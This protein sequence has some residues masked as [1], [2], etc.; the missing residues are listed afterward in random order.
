MV[1]TTLLASLLGLVVAGT[2]SASS[3]SLWPYPS[4]ASLS[5][6]G[7]CLSLSPSSFSFSASGYAS[8]SSVLSAALSRY[9]RLSFLP[10]SPSQPCLGGVRGSLT[11]LLVDVLTT[12]EVLGPDT[13][14]SYVLVVGWSN[15]TASEPISSLTARTVFGALRGLETFSQLVFDGAD[16][17]GEEFRIPQV[18]I[19]D[20]P[21]NNYRAI[22]IDTARIF[23]PVPLLK[24]FLDAMV[25]SKFNVLY[26][27]LT[28]NYQWT[29]EI[30][31]YPDLAT[32]CQPKGEGFYTQSDIA[33]LV[34]YAF[35]RGIRVIPEIDSPGHFDTINCYPE[36]MT[37]AYCPCAGA[38]DQCV[39]PTTFRATP[40]PS[41]SALWSFFEDLHGE[42]A[43]LF[44]D[45]Y[46]AI[47]GDE[48]WLQPWACSPAVQE[49]MVGEKLETLDAAAQW[50]EEAL[51][52]ITRKN[53][54]R[55]MMWWP[56]IESPSSQTIHVVWNGWPVIGGCWKCDFADFTGR[57]QDVLLSGPWYLDESGIDWKQW[58]QI[59]PLDFDGGDKKHML[60]GMGT[61]WSDL[62]KED[63]VTVA[64]PLMNSVAEQL[65]APQTVT[66]TPFENTETE[67]RY[68][69]QCSRLVQRGVLEQAQCEAL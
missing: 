49:W 26:L 48:A 50:Y 27:H 42:M 19:A 66:G 45:A 64:W 21:R 54:K 1:Q 44:P 36:M 6:S 14:E 58:Y 56:G 12:D 8:S 4:S 15:E 35:A 24:L 55:E 37:L 25:L 60:G 67:K 52:N 16:G 32:K 13:D 63:I 2:T 5:S 18:N 30:N 33:E 43:T 9:E 62:V 22:M 7:G 61:I 23:R 31:K 34:S 41:S 38:G 3:L 28:D 65:W 20:S 17:N 51:I 40:D 59:D 29:L 69:E 53:N 46:T 68:K 10:G 39:A 11:S 57:G 47:G